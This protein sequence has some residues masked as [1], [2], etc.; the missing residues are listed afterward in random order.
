[1]AR[2]RVSQLAL[3]DKL[4][5]GRGAMWRRLD[6]QVPF[7]VSELAAAADFFGVPLETLIA[8]E[9]EGVSA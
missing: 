9:P 8:A 4:G 3:A 2:R 1:M 7:R 5:L 6:G